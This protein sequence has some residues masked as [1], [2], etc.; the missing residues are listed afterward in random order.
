MSELLK[1][2]RD[3][4]LRDRDRLWKRIKQLESALQLMYE[5]YA[6]EHYQRAEN[7]VGEEEIEH[8]QARACSAVADLLP[9]LVA[10]YSPPEPE[11]FN[12]DDDAQERQ[13]AWYG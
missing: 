9:D 10:K 5:A 1:G 11:W 7:G 13:T 4:L 12:P 2:Q 3:S 6:A 8:M